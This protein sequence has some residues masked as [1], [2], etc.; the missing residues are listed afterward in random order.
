M[1]DP[2]TPTRDDPARVAALHRS[3]ALDMGRSELLD[4]IA[5]LAATLTG[6]PHAAVNLIDETAQYQA[7]AHGDLPRRV[8]RERSMCAVVVDENAEVYAPDA[9]RDARFE[10]SP[11]VDGRDGDI[12]FYA[13]WPL[14][15]RDGHALGTLCVMDDRPRELDAGQRAALGTLARQ[16]VALF[17][18]HRRTTLLTDALSEVDKLAGTDVL[19]GLAN[20][21]VLE[22]YL[23]VSEPGTTVLFGDLDGFKPVNDALGHPVGDAV[24]R[25][26][27][28]RL[29]AAVRSGDLVCRYGGDEFVVVCPGMTPAAADALVRRLED[30]LPVPVDATGRVGAGVAHP[31]DAGERFAVGASIGVTATVAGEAVADLLER[32]DAAMYARKRER[33]AAGSGR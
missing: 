25:E 31:G 27:A 30:A 1:T 4:D 12:R 13:G 21:R 32:A 15:D 22:E 3:G 23:D 20:R 33:A 6:T 26:V 2:P 8:P 19:T 16:A 10:G 17:E 24:L 11:W 18:L 29:R 7:A 5:S 14:R 28:R 9:S